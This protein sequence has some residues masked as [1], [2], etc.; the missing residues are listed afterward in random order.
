MNKMKEIVFKKE[1]TFRCTHCHFKK[2][3]NPCLT[4]ECF[5]IVYL[6]LSKSNFMK[7]IFA[8]IMSLMLLTSMS[9]AQAKQDSKAAKPATSHVK[10]DGTPDKRFKE[11]KTPAK[12]S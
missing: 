4:N 10:K 6:N 11:N 2:M 1:C 9:F 7:K 12:K 3:I 8:V 5:S